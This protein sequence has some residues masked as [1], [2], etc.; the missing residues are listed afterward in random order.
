M[1]RDIFGGNGP[2][3]SEKS[4]NKVAYRYNALCRSVGWLVG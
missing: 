1:G 3:S 4:E 2:C